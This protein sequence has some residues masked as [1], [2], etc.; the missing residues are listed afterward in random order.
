MTLMSRAGEGGGVQKETRRR[1]RP[2]LAEQLGRRR[3]DSE[4]S[5]LDSFKRKREDEEEQERLRAEKEIEEEFLKARKVGRSPPTKKTEVVI[6]TAET[7]DS[8][9]TE[10]EKEMDVKLDKLMEA[11]LAVKKDM[12]ELRKDNRDLR[13]G[14][15]D[16]RDEWKSRD[17]IWEKER[18]EMRG[19]IEVLEA[20]KDQA[21]G[22]TGRLEGLERKEETR[23]KR[24][25]RNNIT[26]RGEDLPRKETPKDTVEY[27][28]RHELQVE[29]EIEEAYWVGKGE[30]RGLLIAKLKSWQQKRAVML[31]KGTLKEKK[32]FIDNDLTKK[33]REIQKNIKDIA[34]AEREQGAKVKV[35]Y[36]KV[37]INDKTFIWKE[38]GG[39]KEVNFRS[40]QSSVN[41]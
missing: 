40:R 23:E 39:L 36:R 37:K 38:D 41:L 16:L 26:L 8:Q 19:R 1:G 25:R 33:E 18:K 20:K 35:G 32:L 9:K 24:E 10:Q 22:L 2:S 34:K 27:V 5:I 7:P 21:E 3:A 28:L 30:K 6:R 31:K 15:Q 17:E 11:V 13:Q 12:E 4:G 14:M 29:A